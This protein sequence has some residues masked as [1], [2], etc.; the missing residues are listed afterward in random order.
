MSVCMRKIVQIRWLEGAEQQLVMPLRLTR[1]T[2]LGQFL[3]A[4]LVWEQL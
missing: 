4:P 2:G 1:P 3:G